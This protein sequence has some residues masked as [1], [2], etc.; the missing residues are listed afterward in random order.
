MCLNLLDRQGIHPFFQTH[1]AVEFA[2]AVSE[3]TRGWLAELR[4][5][6]EGIVGALDRSDIWV[7][8][9]MAEGVGE[10][11]P[12]GFNHTGNFAGMIY[13]NRELNIV[14]PQDILKVV[15]GWMRVAHLKDTLPGVR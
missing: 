1:R 7:E 3:K 8:L 10:R 4:G 6:H 9:H 15:D 14:F 13:P 12:Q 5:L 11:L 2:R